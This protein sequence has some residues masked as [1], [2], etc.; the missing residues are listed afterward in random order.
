MRKPKSCE[1]TTIT[2]YEFVLGGQSYEAEYTR[3]TNNHNSYF[4]F[5]L[6]GDTCADGY[7]VT[8]HCTYCDYSDTYDQVEFCDD[9]SSE[10]FV[11]AYDLWD[12]GMCDG[13]YLYF[14]S[15]PCNQRGDAS[16]NYGCDRTPTG[17]TDPLTGMQE[18]YCEDCGTYSYDENS[19]EHDK[20]NCI[21]DGAFRFKLVRDGE[22]LLE[23]SYTYQRKHHDYEL[24]GNDLITEGTDCTEGVMQTYQCAVCG[25]TKT[26]YIYH[27]AVVLDEMVDLTE[28][29]AVCGSTLDLYACLCGAQKGYEFGGE[30]GCDVN[31]ENWEETK[32]WIEG[33]IDEHQEST[34]GET[35]YSYSYLIKCAVTDPDACGLTIRMSRYWLK[36]GCTV[37]E[38]ETWQ[39]GYDE[40]TGTW[41][42]ELT[43]ATGRTH[44]YHD[45]VH[46]DVDETLEDGYANGY[47]YTC[48]D[49]GSYYSYVTTYD[50]DENLVKTEET[51][52]NTLK[53]GERQKKCYVYNYEMV[54]GENCLVMHSAEYT[55]ADGSLN[56]DRHNYEYDLANCERICTYTDSVGMTDVTKE[57]YH[58]SG[59]YQSSTIDATCT[60][61]GEERWWYVCNACGESY[62]ESYYEIQPGHDWSWNEELQMDVCGVCGLQNKN[63]ASGSIVMEDLTDTYGNGEN[64]VIGYWNQD[65][66]DYDIMVSVILESTGE[67]ILLNITEFT[68]HTVENDGFNGLSFNK[69]T[70]DA[71]AAEAVS[72]VEGYEG[73][74]AIRISFVPVDGTDTLDYAI[75]FDSATAQ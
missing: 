64:Y 36:E 8:V 24:I 70:A 51:W 62:D 66:I 58:H 4:S 60:Q 74:Y 3:V 67:Q 68:D 15:C 27:H 37:T 65:E 14:Y 54:S 19:V 53:N 73:T 5:E 13:G 7:Y 55:E 9:H 31:Q 56:W 71:A 46:T 28:H 2:H 52:V 20:A 22:T 40:A 26:E 48:S 30:P 32:H 16:Y 45:Y 44:S 29:G 72:T 42:A 34:H 35:T 21:D 75:T 59:T 43:I 17:N 63:G 38:Y 47:K 69:A 23:R 49:C 6:L 41:S 18:Y 57:A 61:H 1:E 50:A 10:L 25:A 12:Y 39:L 33:V 11:G